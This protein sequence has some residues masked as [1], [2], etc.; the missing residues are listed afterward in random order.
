MRGAF[1]KVVAALC[2]LIPQLVQTEAAR[3]C[4]AV[5]LSIDDS[6]P[7]VLPPLWEA[8]LHIISSIEVRPLV[9]SKRNSLLAG[10]AGLYDLKIILQNF[11]TF[12][13]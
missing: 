10:R 5:L 11:L 7:V 9:Q 3:A 13:Q 1:F 6:D 8:V 4:S 2:E 12:S